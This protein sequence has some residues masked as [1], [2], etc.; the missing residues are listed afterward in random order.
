MGAVVQ[1]IERASLERGGLDRN[2][3]PCCEEEELRGYQEAR[4]SLE[5]KRRA[6]RFEPGGKRRKDPAAER[7][8]LALS[9]LRCHRCP[10]RGKREHLLAR[11]R[12]IDNRLERGR[13]LLEELRSSYW[14]E[15]ER[16]A[17]VLKQFGCVVD[18]SIALEGRIVA[19][20]RHDNELLLARSL[21]SRAFRG[22]SPAESALLLSC[23]IEEPRQADPSAAR[24][25]LRRRP[26]L[27]RRIR[28]LEETV[29]EVADAQD[30]YG[31]RIPVSFQTQFVAAVYHWAQGEESWARL[32]Q[33]NYGGHEGDLIRAFRRLIDLCRQVTEIETLPE[34]LRSTMNEAAYLLDRGIVFECALV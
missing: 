4:G 12:R 29:R 14:T 21:K 9:R 13:A 22:A 27:R 25:F 11:L 20:L 5:D 15:F 17:R 31:V 10:Y 34:G 26:D 33:R 32:V 7:M 28:G 3:F 6:K 1:E 23:L 2:V 24:M 8:A 30:A 19:A 16:V 18:D